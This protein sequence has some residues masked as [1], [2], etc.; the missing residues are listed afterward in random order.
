[1]TLITA[2]NDMQ[3]HNSIMQ[4]EE[5]MLKN[6]YV[7]FKDVISEELS[8][9]IKE[10]IRSSL[11]A[12]GASENEPF[13]KQYLSTIKKI[14]PFDVNIQLRRHLNFAHFPQKILSIPEVFEFMLRILGPDLA[15]LT[16]A[17]LPVNIK[18][19]SEY[20]LTKKPHQEFWSGAGYRTYVLWAPIIF[21]KNSGG[22]EIF[23]GSHLWGHIPHRNREPLYV[24]DNV[25]RELIDS[26][27][28]SDRDIVLFHALTLHGT[29]PNS[30]DYPRLAYVTHLRNIFEDDTG[31]EII[32]NWEIFHLSATSRIMRRCGNPHLS[33]FRTST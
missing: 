18:G 30:E 6:G 16:D 12:M 28:F 3:Q 25:E 7:V 15:F 9:Q 33:P 11:V 8:F 20:Y 31:F 13:D 17:E 27:Q 5:C 22:L 21:P 26:S 23:K 24:P 29:I 10:N 2:R 4:Q 1:M 14:P 19:K 32:K